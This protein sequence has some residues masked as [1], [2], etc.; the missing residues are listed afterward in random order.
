MVYPN[1]YT[2]KQK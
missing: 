2:Y 1:V